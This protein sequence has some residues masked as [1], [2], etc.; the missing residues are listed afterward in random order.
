[1]LKEGEEEEKEKEKNLLIVADES[2]LI[3][4]HL[5]TDFNQQFEL[6]ETGNSSYSRIIM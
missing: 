5:K 6:F 4:K 1:M 3:S 2:F